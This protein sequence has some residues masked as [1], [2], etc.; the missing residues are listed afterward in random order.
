MAK[1]DKLFVACL[2]AAAFCAC[3]CGDSGKSSC[4]EAKDCGDPAVY[5]CNTDNECEVRADAHCA[6]KKADSGETDVD[7]GGTCSSKCAIGKKCSVDNDCGTGFCGEKKVCEAKTC[8][9]NDECKNVGGTCDDTLHQC[10]TCSDGLK[11]GTETDVDCGGS[12][13]AKCEGGKTCKTGSDCENG[14]CKDG[15]CSSEKA[16]VADPNDLVIN[17]V[18]DS[19]KASSVFDLNNDH[20]ACEFIEI[21]NTSDKLV[22]LDGLSL[23][24]LRTDDDKNKTVSVP[25]SGVLPAKNLLVVH[26]CDADDLP[27]PDD[28]VSFWAATNNGEK[29]T[30]LFSLTSTASYEMVI[31]DGTAST[32]AVEVVV[33]TTKNKSSLNRSPE[34]DASSPMKLTTELKE[35]DSSVAS[36]ATPG[37]CL[38]GGTY[39][40]DCKD[41]GSNPGPGPD[42]KPDPSLTTCSSVE[43][44]TT[45]DFTCTTEVDS[46]ISVGHCVQL[47]TDDCNA[48]GNGWSCF[49]PEFLDPDFDPTDFDPDDS[50]GVCVSWSNGVLDVSETDI[51]CG[52]QLC[53]SEADYTKYEIGDSF[54]CGEGK[55]CNFN[56]D[57]LSGVCTGGRCVGGG[58]QQPSASP[59]DLVINEVMAAEDTTASSKSFFT[60]NGDRTKECKFI[61]IVNKTNKS[62]SVDNC[63]VILNRTDVDNKTS[64]SALTGTIQPN[65]VIVV[66]NCKE[67]D[68]KLGLPAGALEATLSGVTNITQ[69]GA[70]DA[71]IQCGE[72]EGKH[73]EVPKALKG[74]SMTLAEDLDTETDMTK[75]T[76]VNPNA[77][78]SPGYCANGG[79]FTENCTMDCHNEGESCGGS[80]A[81]CDNG[82]HCNSEA[83]CKSGL[84]EGNVCIASTSNVGDYHNLFINEVLLSP[85]T[86][87]SP[88]TFNPVQNVNG[89]KF[90]EILNLDADHSFALDGLYLRFENL[91]DGSASKVVIDLSGTINANNAF[92]VLGSDCSE[93][94]VLPEGVNS[95][96]S[97]TLKSVAM[98]KN[99]GISIDDGTEEADPTHNFVWSKIS[100]GNGI[101]QT[102][103]PDRDVESEIKKHNDASVDAQ[104]GW[105][106]S[107]GYCVNGGLFVDNCEIA[108]KP[109]DKLPN[110]EGCMGHTDCESGFCN[111]DYICE[112]DESM[113]P[114]GASC[115][116]NYEC[117]SGVCKDDDTCQ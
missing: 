82:K 60:M 98:G 32:P 19:A 69:G 67:E 10:V 50:L 81:K 31:S 84:C 30:K 8:A 89:C 46:R 4:S 79:L 86:G 102:H 43:Q 72:I 94:L 114:S 20:V 70:F 28:A 11:N 47:C 61:E 3:G 68:G 33:S 13:S 71:W 57:C 7:C 87:S 22:S 100:S 41:G 15:T 39:S 55:A 53:H 56:G 80:C 38:N 88:L 1:K 105:L 103:A 83:D 35:A 93:S 34:F 108:S 49:L 91:D 78:A 99:W 24:M 40:K 54:K 111:S 27:L 44:C 74:T 107:P 6:N 14:V 75:H 73:K 112:E 2:C 9:S 23:E 36:F 51:D 42:P 64:K 76:D 59:S 16:A 97:T 96:T 48:M 25:L 109:S 26:T 29:V 110:G 101:S 21:A 95:M 92:V 58:S 62:L 17:E 115:T 65:N 106:A 5:M 77:F 117:K 52:C 37:Y 45:E 85:K 18:F 116:S 90:V 12:C 113:K 66:H 104:E 63:S